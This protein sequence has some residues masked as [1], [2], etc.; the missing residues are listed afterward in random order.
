MLCELADDT[1]IILTVLSSSRLV[2]VYSILAVSILYNY[3][4]LPTH[5][6]CILHYHSDH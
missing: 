4:E 1:E 2:N 3:Y 5:Q 6:W